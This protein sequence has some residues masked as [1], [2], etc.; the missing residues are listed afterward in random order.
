VWPRSEAIP[1][2]GRCAHAGDSQDGPERPRWEVADV[3]RL[4]GDTYRQTQDVSVAQQKVIDAIIACRTAQLGG[5]TERCPQCG[6]E[7]YA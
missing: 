4:Y 3:F 1:L 5:H 7:R 6:F 2:T